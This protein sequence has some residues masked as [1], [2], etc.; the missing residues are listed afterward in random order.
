MTAKLIM[1]AAEA[2]AIALTLLKKNLMAKTNVRKG[3]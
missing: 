3:L 1:S 2:N